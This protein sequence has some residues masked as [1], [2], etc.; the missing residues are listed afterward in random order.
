MSAVPAEIEH[1]PVSEVLPYP[2]N[3]PATRYCMVQGAAAE[4]VTARCPLCRDFLIARQGRSGP[5]FHCHCGGVRRRPAAPPPDGH[6]V[7]TNG[8]APAENHPQLEG[9]AP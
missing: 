8:D 9:A 1:E 3:C 2:W 5:Y 4:V 6:A 7:C